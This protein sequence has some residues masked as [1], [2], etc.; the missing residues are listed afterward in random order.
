VK[1]S[2]EECEGDSRA[3]GLC[4]KHY[5]RMKRTGKLTTTRRM[6]DFWSKVKRGTPEE[7]WPWLGFTRE[8]GH[9]LTSHKG[10]PMHT[11]RKAW[12]LSNGP[13][14]RGLF[15]CHK[16]DNKVC[17]NPDHLYLGTA[18]DNA[19]D[20][21]EKPPFELRGPRGRR[22]LLTERELQTLWKM[23]RERG[24]SLRECADRF[25]VHTHTICKYITNMRRAKLE[26]LR[27]LVRRDTP[28]I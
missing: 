25:G 15:A 8:S 11:S 23:R 14:P 2:V 21:F 24:A 10:L 19:L 6:G 3:K 18:A 1:C 27:Q 13:I 26:R 5:V 9:G 20:Q 28:A 16:C 7:C 22:T 12:I 4:L 17:C